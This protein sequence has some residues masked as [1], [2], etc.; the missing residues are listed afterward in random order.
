MITANVIKI[1]FPF[2]DGDVLRRASLG[3]HF[4]ASYV[5]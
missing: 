5:C 2:K 4:A 3:I 1:N